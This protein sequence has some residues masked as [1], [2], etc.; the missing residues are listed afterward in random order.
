[1]NSPVR[2]RFASLYLIGTFV[3][4]AATLTAAKLSS[5]RKSE[6]LARPLD[7][8][9]RQLSPASYRNR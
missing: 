4:L 5:H 8:I 1:M 3:L 2:A 9:S 7:T 6:V